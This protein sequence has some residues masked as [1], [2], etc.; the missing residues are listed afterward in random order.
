M[1]NAVVI[2]F[3]TGLYHLSKDNGYTYCHYR[4]DFNDTPCN[5]KWEDAPPLRKCHHCDRA[6][7][8]IEKAKEMPNERKHA[9]D[10][11]K[12]KR[13]MESVKP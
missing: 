1:T 8:K 7:A 10:L 9:K 13:W 2:K 3:T 5:I 4:I 11:E 6:A 12:L